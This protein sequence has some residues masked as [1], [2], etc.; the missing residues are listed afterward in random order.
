MPVVDERK[1][2]DYKASLFAFLAQSESKVT[3]KPTVAPTPK[4]KQPM[5]GQQGIEKY[6]SKRQ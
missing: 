1:E 6:I 4:K 5:Q 3:V 2:L